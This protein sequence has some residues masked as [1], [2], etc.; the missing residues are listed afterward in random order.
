MDFYPNFNPEYD[1]I[2][3]CVELRYGNQGKDLFPWTGISF[4]RKTSPFKKV[5]RS[6]RPKNPEP[7]S[8]YDQQKIDAIL[9]KI[10]KSGYDTLTK[11]EKDYLFRAGKN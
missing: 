5:Y 8:G 10:S 4:E 9:D 6:P 2:L 1:T 3:P 7:E 11:E